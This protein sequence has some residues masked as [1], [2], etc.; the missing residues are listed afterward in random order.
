MKAN[1]F[2]TEINCEPTQPIGL[3]D[4]ILTT[5]SC[6]ADQFG[7]WLKDFKFPLMLN[8][9]GTTYNPIS[10]HRA[11]TD[12]VELKLDESLI[13]ERHGIW[14]HFDYHSQWSA[15]DKT[16]LLLNIKNCQ[17]Q[18]AQFLKHTSVLIIT[19]GTA[20]VYELQNDN[21]LVANCH[22]MPSRQ[23]RKRLLQT[24]EIIAS[25]KN[26]YDTLK[27]FNPS[28]RVIVTVSP[29]R[30]M[31][32]TLALNSVSK[33]TLR[34][35]CHTL[36]EQYEAVDYFPSYEI[37][38]DDLRDY[39]FYERDK[40]HPTEEALD[41]ISHK[42]SDQYFTQETRQFINKWDTIRQAMHHRAYHPD[43]PAH[44]YFLKDLLHKLEEVHAQIPVD[45]EI[46]LIKS[47]LH[48]NA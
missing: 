32:D 11:L 48:L 24:E 21:H 35:A 16:S 27:S 25:F 47:Q 22:K 44:Q 42:F 43:S 5:G 8:P 19:Y 13:T 3:K 28:L 18:V 39:R 37:M 2:R 41:Y 31:K 6:F 14:Y 7:E 15:T 46:K 38:M 23:F 40:I 30:H 45:E 33:A 12:S 9:F 1:T 10:I 4:A 34:L 29:V 26:L 20:W 36:S 17:K